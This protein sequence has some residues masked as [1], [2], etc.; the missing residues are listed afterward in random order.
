MQQRNPILARTLKN[1]AE[2][3]R[4]AMAPTKLRTYHCD[5]DLF[6]AL[7][8]FAFQKNVKISHVVR[9]AI[10][11]YIRPYFND[12]LKATHGNG[13]QGFEKQ[14]EIAQD[15][16]SIAPDGW[17]GESRPLTPEEEAA[18]MRGEI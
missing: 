17:I 14:I 18:V 4:R 1:I 5:D 6:S 8:T 12:L 7:R 15:A 9:S 2:K 16:L 10:R 3:K 13:I 11:E